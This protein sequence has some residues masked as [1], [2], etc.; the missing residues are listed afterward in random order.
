MREGYQEE[1]N[2][3]KWNMRRSKRRISRERK[4]GGNEE[5]DEGKRGEYHGGEKSEA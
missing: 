5:K 3:G 1:E 4:Y 2:N